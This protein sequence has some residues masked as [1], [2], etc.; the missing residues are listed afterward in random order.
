MAPS[1]EGCLR[2]LCF[3]IAGLKA[4]SAVWRTMIRQSMQ[5]RW[6][7]GLAEEFFGSRPST[8]ITG[9]SPAMAN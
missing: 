8:W 7:K 4:R 3:V 9:S 2:V 1:L 5:K 6:L